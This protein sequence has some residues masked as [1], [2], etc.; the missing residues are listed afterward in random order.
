MS[1]IGELEEADDLFTEFGS[2]EKLVNSSSPVRACR[3]HVS[4]EN[5]LMARACGSLLSFCTLLRHPINRMRLK[6]RRLPPRRR[7]TLPPLPPLLQGQSR[8]SSPCRQEQ[9]TSTPTC[10]AAVMMGLALCSRHRSQ[11]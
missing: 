5:K 9:P 2:P 3:L 1:N 6:I 4:V 11:K 8:P 7:Q 10:L